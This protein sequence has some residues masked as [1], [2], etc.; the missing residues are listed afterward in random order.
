MKKRTTISGWGNFP[1]ILAEELYPTRKKDYEKYQEGSYHPRGLG[2][3]YGDASLPQEDFISLNTGRLDHFIHFDKE[4]HIL[5][6][7]AGVSFEQ[8][9]EYFIPKGYFL[10]VTP[11]TKY[12][13][14]GGAIASNVHGKNH[15]HCGSIENFIIEFD[16]LTPI[17]AFTCSPT[18][19]E[20]LF[21]ATISG[22]GLTGLI[23]KAKLKLTPIESSFFHTKKIAA[24]NLEEI[25]KLFSQYDD[26]Y[27]YSVAWMDTLA[28]GA[29][30]G[31]S[32]LMLGRHTTLEELTAKERKNPLQV[33]DKFKI[34]FPTYL[35]SAV[36]NR[37]FLTGFNSFLYYFYHLQQGEKF[38]LYEPFFYPLDMMT[39]WNRMYGRKG[40]LQY[41][42]V[43][44][45]PNGEEGVRAALEF[46]SSQ[47]MGSF[48]SVLKRCGDDYAMIP[49]AKK[50]YTLALDIPLRSHTLKAL[51]ELDKIV[52]NFNGRVYLSKD[53]RLSPETF[54]IMYPEYQKWLDVI[55]KYNPNKKVWSLMAQRLEL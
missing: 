9:L 22:Y 18:Q 28:S 11:G 34:N 8:I 14:L 23:T 12:V 40:F 20:E 24:R 15:H 29:D 37:L 32:I 50:G 44:P 19:N 7:E 48:L 52:M 35:P 30:L 2:R 55:K 4:N 6:A 33:V 42:C 16:I 1:S 13:T 47:G 54:R 21:R 3:S 36:L 39:N 25:F 49:F 53:A 51:D 41:Q 31:R 26:E 43:I 17:G 27:E 10:P 38:E 46:L 5:E 45:D